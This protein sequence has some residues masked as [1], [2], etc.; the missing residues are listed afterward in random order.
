MAVFGQT[1]AGVHLTLLAANSLTI[2]FVFLLGRKLFGVTAGWVTCASYGVM[3][4]SPAVAGAWQLMRRILCIICGAGDM[5]VVESRR[6]KTAKDI[7]LQWIALWAGIFDEA[8]GNMALACFGS[9][10]SALAAVRNRSLFTR[11]LPEL[12]WCMGWE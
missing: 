9:I 12:V 7:F 4:V 2:V 5:A 8:A 11:D 10:F 1:T 3:S 6:I